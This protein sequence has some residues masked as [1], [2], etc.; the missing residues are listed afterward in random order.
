M[1]EAL[2]AQPFQQAM[3]GMHSGSATQLFISVT[4]SEKRQTWQV[5]NIT[6]LFGHAG[7]HAWLLQLLSRY[8]AEMPSLWA[9]RQVWRHVVS[10]VAQPPTHWV[11]SSHARLP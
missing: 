7:T 5:L 9:V 4:H 10:P 2:P 1:Q 11:S 6:P 3:S 8:A